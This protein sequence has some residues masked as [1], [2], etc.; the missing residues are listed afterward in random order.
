MV[1]S[2]TVS[3]EGDSSRQLQFT[4]E[5][6]WDGVA[7]GTW[8]KQQENGLGVQ[9]SSGYWSYGGSEGEIWL[10]ESSDVFCTVRVDS[11]WSKSLLEGTTVLGQGWLQKTSQGDVNVLFRLEATG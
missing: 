4:L 8:T 5:P 6:L 1:V 11:D 7:S 9:P 10:S 3:M 2:L